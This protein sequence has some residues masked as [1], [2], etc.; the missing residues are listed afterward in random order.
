M[1]SLR[2]EDLYPMQAAIDERMD[3][4]DD[5]F[6]LTMFSFKVEVYELANKIEFFKFWKHNKGKDGQLEEYVDG[7]H[8]LLS[9]GLQTGHQPKVVEVG[10]IIKPLSYL[11]IFTQ[12]EYALNQFKYYCTLNKYLELFEYYLE[13]GAMLGFDSQMIKEA[14]IKKN[15]INHERQDIGY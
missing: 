5:R 2:T 3:Y 4:V 14:Y 9:L 8:F 11:A 13:L 10:R 15:E 12:I 1:I 7:L 6:S